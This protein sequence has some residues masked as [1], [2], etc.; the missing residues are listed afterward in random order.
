[1]TT[2]RSPAELARLIANRSATLV[3]GFARTLRLPPRSIATTVR[4]AALMAVVEVL[5]RRTSLPRVASLLRVRLDL[6]PS[7]S[8]IEPLDLSEL[9]AVARRQVTCTNRVADAW[10]FSD[11]PCLRRTLV[12][13]RLL[14]SEDPAIRIGLRDASAGLTAH[15]WLELGGRPLEDISDVGAFAIA[16]GDVA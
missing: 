6:H 13:G 15:A 1:M 16:G 8:T 12:A 11:G 10:P 5:V 2:T 3:W 9:S 14:R 4:V 7:T